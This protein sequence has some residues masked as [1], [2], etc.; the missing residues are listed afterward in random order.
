MYVCLYIYLYI[1]I[2]VHKHIPVYVSNINVVVGEPDFPT[3]G[4]KTALTPKV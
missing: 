4:Y 3:G 1:Q 2:C